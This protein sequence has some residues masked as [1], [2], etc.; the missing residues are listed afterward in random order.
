MKRIVLTTFG[1]LGDLHP[2]IA[3]ALGLKA[4]G[5]E[6]IIA[7]SGFYRQKIEALGVGFRAVRPDHPDL[8]ADPG[9]VRRLM[10][11]RKG[12]ECV[13]CE[14]IMPV[15]RESYDDTLTAAEGADLLVSHTLTFTT[16]LVAEKKGIPWASTLLQPIGFMSVY[17]P[18]VLPPAPF[19]AKLRFL[20]PIFHRLLFGIG[21]WTIRSWCDPWH[22]LRA[23]IGLPPRTEN[24]LF[25]GQHAPSLVLAMFSKVFADKQ[26]D[27]P[28]QTVVSGFPFYDQDGEAGCRWSWVTSLT[29]ARRPSCSRSAPRR[30][31]M[32]GRST[33]RAPLLPVRWHAGQFSSSAKTHATDLPH[34][35]MES[36]PS[37]TPPT[38]SFSQEPP[39]SFTRAASARRR[40]R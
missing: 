38:R 21:K 1:S 8:Q 28:P 34:F 40:R 14:M 7:T 23:E 32:P 25:E 39:P 29:P 3:V 19:L 4:R 20:G 2:Y 15:L 35:L 36:R 5:H 26:R 33:S 24:P 11:I 10:D 6:A 13:I 27:W 12:T 37:I 31:W 18:P 17:D 9:L 22:R 16:R 30:Y